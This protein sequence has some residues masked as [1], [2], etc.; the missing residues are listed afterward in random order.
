MGNPNPKL[1]TRKRNKSISR[2]ARGNKQKISNYNMDEAHGSLGLPADANHAQVLSN[3]LQYGPNPSLPR[4]PPKSVVK[5][6]L[7]EQQAENEVLSRDLD[8]TQRDL[9]VA[10]KDAS[11]KTEKIKSLKQQVRDLS[12]ALQ[13]EKKKSRATIAKLLQDAE[14]IMC[15]ACDIENEA[16]KKMTAA[17]LQLSREQERGKRNVQAAQLKV[18][19]EKQRSKLNL[20][21]ERRRSAAHL[22][23]G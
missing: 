16:D 12:G 4:S 1:P 10:Q 15:D 7:K 17:E 21:E 8:V 11:Q 13:V 5:A 23:S 14:Q 9:G 19:I 22:A 2:H 3:T 6:R 18:S 20:Q